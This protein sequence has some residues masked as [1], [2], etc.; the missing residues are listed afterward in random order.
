MVG[1]G[2][3]VG[4]LIFNVPASDAQ[5]DF[6]DMSSQGT[7]SLVSHSSRKH[8][9][10]RY[11][12]LQ[13]KSYDNILSL[14]GG[15]DGQRFL[16]GKTIV[17]LPDPALS[18]TPTA[19][20]PFKQYA[21]GDLVRYAA[22]LYRVT[23][24]FK[25]GRLFDS[26]NLELFDSNGD[27]FNPSPYDSDDF[28]FDSTNFDRGD[29][30]P[31]VARSGRFV[32]NITNDGLIKLTPDLTVGTNNKIT[33]LE[34]IQ[35][36]NREVYHN[37]QLGLM[38]I[39]NITA[40][41]DV[42]Y[43]QDSLDSS[44]GGIIELI[45]QDVDSTIHVETSIVGKKKYTSPNGVVL[46]N[47]MK[48]RFL[49]NVY[50]TEYADK[51]FYVEGVGTSIE[52][53]PVSDLISP[54]TWLD[55]LQTTFDT[56]A[57]DS[58]EFDAQTNSPITKDYHVIN[59]SSRDKSAWSRINR[60]F[61]EDVIKAS[62]KY[63]SYAPVLDHSYR[64]KR[65]II[66][67]VPN[68]QLENFGKVAKAPVD[69]ID[70]NQT[71][72]FSNVEGTAVEYIGGVI[73]AYS[74]EQIPLSDGMRVI[75][76]ADKD[77]QVRNNIYVV[78]WI[79]PLS[80]VDIRSAVF[81]ADGVTSVFDLNF[82]VNSTLNLEVQ[83]NG[84]NANT[85]GYTWVINSNQL[86][87]FVNTVPPAGTNITA[88]LVIN[89]QIHL[90]LADD[91]IS[92][93]DTVTITRGAVSQGKQYYFDGTSWV[94][95]QN[96]I[97]VNQAPLFTLVDQDK[98]PL[99]DSTKYVS[100]NFVGN[101]IFG[102]R[103]SDTGTTDS[104]LGIKLKYRNFN[105]IG[106]ILFSD[107]IT[108]SEFNYRV[109]VE[110]VAKTTSG[111][112]LIRNNADGS[113]EYLNQWQK[114]EFATQ[115]YQL[116]TFF[117]TQYQ[118]NSFMLNV[119]PSDRQNP[120]D[121]QSILVYVNNVALNSYRYDI[122]VVS[123]QGYLLLDTDLNVGDKLDVKVAS[124]NTTNSTL[125]EIPSNLEFNPLNVEIGEFTL[126][127]MRDHVTKVFEN[128]PDL[129]GPF[130]GS[131]NSRDL[132][133][134]KQY[135]GKIVQNLGSPH[136]AN[137][138]LNDV[139]ANFIDSVIY[140]QREYTRFKNKF[141][142]L[143]Y[144]MPL[145]NPLDPVLSVD[146]VIAEIS[147]NKSQMFSFYA[148]DMIAHGQDFKKLQY[149]V[150]DPSVVD[151]DLTTIFDGT[152]PS[153]KAVSVYKNGTLLVR[154]I[155]YVI[156]V[157]QPIVQLILSKSTN[158]SKITLAIGDQI[159]I[160][161]YVST[162]ASH[163]P[164]TPSKMGLA[165]S[166]VPEIIIDGND[167]N[168]RSVICGHDGSYTAL[169]N[170]HRDAALLEFEKRI[171]N[172][173]KVSYDGKFHDLRDYVPGGFRSTPFKKSEYDLILST[174][175]NSW[176]GKTGLRQSDYHT[177]ESS[178]PWSWNYATTTSRVDGKLMPCAY[179]RGIFQHYFDTDAPN[180]RPWEMLG[181]ADK[182][183]WWEYTY[184]PAPYTRG[185]TVLWTDLE[186]GYIADG[187]R[188]GIDSRF[189]RPN[190]IDYIPVDESGVMLSPLECLVKDYDSTNITGNFTFGDGGPVET[191][192]SQSSEYCFAQQIALALMQPAEYF[193]GNID[194]NR[195]IMRNGQ[196]VYSDTGLRDISTQS[197]H[198]ELDSA[199]NIIHVNSYITWMAEHATSLGLDI[200]SAVGDKLR[201]S[202]VQLSYKVSGFT[203]KK[204]LKVFADQ[205]TPNSTNSSVT[206]PDEDFSVVLSKSAP[207]KSVS[208]SGVIVTKTPDGFSVNGY[209]DVKPYF[210]IETSSTSGRK[211]TLKVGNLSATK[212]IRGDNRF[213]QVPYGTEFLN[214]D[215]VVDFLVSYGRY[216]TRVGFQFTD[217][218]DEDA[219]FYKDWDL[220]AR[221]FMFYAQ[222][223]WDTD[224]A[225]SLSPVGSSIK[226]SAP[227]GA[228]DGLTDKASGTRVLTED[229]RILR[230]DEYSVNRRGRDFSLSVDSSSGVYLLDIDVVNYEHILV[231]ENITRFNDLVYDPSIG[232]RQFRLKLKGNRTGD[233]DGSFG[234]AGFI[235]NEDNI[236][237]WQQ[238]KNYLKGE[239]V[240]FKNAYYT[241]I[242]NVPGA[243]SFDLQVW[244][245]SDYSKI[246][247]GLLPN[248][249]TK[250]G[251]FKKFYDIDSVNLEVDADRLGT[252]LI[253]LRPRPYFEQLQIDDTSQAKFYQGMIT[254]KGSRNSL[255]K[256][257]RAKLDNFDG[258]V[259]FYEDWALR[260]GQYGAT[261]IRQQLQLNIPENKATRDP[262]TIEI[263]NQNDSATTGMISFKPNDIWYKPRVFDKNFLGTR[264]KGTLSGDLINA[265]YVRLDDVNWTCASVA[266]LN[267]S[268]DANLVSQGDSIAVAVAENSEWNVYRVNET[269]VHTKNFSVI[270]NGTATFEF[271]TS[272]DLA[273]DDLVLIKTVNNKPAISGFY[274]V[275]SVPSNT[276]VTVNTS[277]GP[278]VQTKITGALFRLDYQRFENVSKVSGSEPL[279]GWKEND[280]LFIDNATSDGWGVYEKKNAFQ[281]SAAY[282][283]ADPFSISG[284]PSLVSGAAFGTS[285][286]VNMSND[287]MIVGQPGA[288]SIVTYT[289][290]N[291]TL[292]Q[293]SILTSPS[294]GISGFGSSVK[295][296]NNGFAVVT[297]PS[298]GGNTGVVFILQVIP[299]TNRFSIVQALTAPSLI[300]GGKFGYSAAISDDGE[301]IAIGQPEVDHGVV[302]LYH[303]ETQIIPP[304]STQQFVASG[305]TSVF[306]LSGV[307]ANPQSIDALYV[308]RNGDKLIPYVDYTLSGND[309]TMSDIPV[310]GVEIE[311]SV[312][313]AAP[314]MNYTGDGITTTFVLTGDSANPSSIYNLK[315]AINGILMVPYRDYTLSGNNVTFTTAPVSNAGIS[316]QQRTH[317]VRLG[318]Q[319]SAIGSNG[320]RYGASLDFAANG[321]ELI[322]GA[323]S[324][325]SGAGKAYVYN[326]SSVEIISDGTPGA[327]EYPVS[328]QTSRVKVTV[329]G[330]EKIQDFGYGTGEYIVD[331][332][333]SVI[334]IDNPP[335]GSRIVIENNYFF[336]NDTISF[337]APEPNANA[338][339]SVKFSPSESRVF[340]GAPYAD[341]SKTDVGKVLCAVDQGRLYGVNTGTVVN[342]VL[343][344][345][346]YLIINERW[347]PVA[348]G[349]T[350][351]AVISAIQ[352][353]DVPG[354]SVS[355]VGG[356]LH[357]SSNDAVTTNKLKISASN[358]TVLADLGLKTY[359]NQ[360][361]L[362]GPSS[363]EYGMF[364]KEL[365]MSS[366]SL[367]LVV[368]SDRASSS[369]A[370]TFDSN[371]TK[372]DGSA[373]SFSYSTKQSGAVFTYQ[374][375]PYPS[376][377]V[378]ASGSFIP[379][380][381]L[382]SG[383]VDSMDG[384]GSGISI[385]G[386]ILFVGAPGDDTYVSNGGIIF[387]FA[388][389][390]YDRVW[391]LIRSETP[392]VNHTLINRVSLIDTVKNVIVADLDFID[393]YKGKI[394]GVAEQEVTYSTS[395]DPAEYNVNSANQTI[396][397]S[398]MLWGPDQVGQ[399]WWDISAVRW[400][401]YEQGDIDFRVANWGTA[402]P[403]SVVRCYEWIESTV[404]PAQF[405]DSTAFALT[406]SHS[407]IETID[408]FGNS[409]VTYYYWVGGKT[410]VP[411]VSFRSIS[412]NDIEELISN[413]KTAGIPYAA[414]IA[415]NAIALYNCKSYLRD[416]EIVLSIDYDIEENDSNIHA[417][418][419]LISQG[420]VNSSP[421]S[422]IITKLIDSLA[423]SDSDGR[424]VPDVKLTAGRRYGKEFRPRQ[425]MFR[426]RTSAL[427]VAIDYINSILSATPILLE[428]NVSNIL[429]SEN[430]PSANSGQWNE[431]VA[432][433]T[434]L[435]YINKVILP[436][437]YKILVMSNDLVASRWTIHELAYLE[438]GITK[439]WKLNRVQAYDNS[440]Y[441][442]KTNWVAAGESNNVIPSL[443]VNYSYQ[444][445]EITPSNGLVVKIKDD[446][447][448]YYTIMK[449]TGT[450]WTPIVIEQATIK[451]YDGIWDQS[452]T[453]QGFDNESFDLQMFDSWPTVEI[454]NILRAVYDD[455]FVDDLSIEMNN[456]FF[457]MMQHLMQ[458]QKYVDW[459]FKT[460]FIKVEQ[461]QH[462][463]TQIPVYQKDNQDL[464]SQY[465]NETKPFHTKIREF[466]LKYNGEDEVQSNVSDFDVP[467]Y[468]VNST[469]GYRS[470]NGSET[471][472]QFILDLEPYTAW[473][474]NHT[475][476]VESI[477][478][479][480][481]GDGYISPPTLSIVGG[482]GSGATAVAEVLGGQITAVRITNSGSG[483]TT[484]PEVVLSNV[485]GSGALLAVRLSN[486][487][488]RRI[489]ETIKFDRTS[490]DNTGFLVQFKDGEGGLIDIRNEKISK[491]GEEPKGVIDILLSI[492]EPTT[493]ITS[494][495]GSAL[496]DYR[497]FNDASGRIQVAYL[498]RAGG[499]N[500]Y[501][502]QDI[503]RTYS[504]AGI[505]AL[506]LS[507][508]TVVVDSSFTSY[509]SPVDDWKATTLYNPGDVV[510]YA[511]NA[512]KAMTR[513]TSGTQF[514]FG[515]VATLIGTTTEEYNLNIGSAQAWDTLTSYSVNEYF[516][517]LTNTGKLYRVTSP[518]TSGLL[519]SV[520]SFAL[521]TGE[522]FT[523]HLDRTWAYYSPTTGQFGKDLG[524]LFKGVDYP[525]VKVIG[526]SFSMQPGFDV[527]SYDIGQF[528]AFV[529]DESGAKVLDPAILDQ[530]IYS[531]FT[532]TALGTRP[533]DIIIR[534]NGFA[535]VYSSHAPEE[536]VPGR[537]FDTLDMKVYT[538]PS[539]DWTNSGFGFDVALTTI[540]YTDG[541]STY[542]F[543]NPT[544]AV[545]TVIVFTAQAGRLRENDGFTIDR[546]TNTITVLANLL[547]GDKIF[548]YA[549]DQGGRG[550]LFTK[551]FI[552]D[553]STAGYEI[554][555]DE[556][557]IGELIVSID[558]QYVTNWTV[559]P[560][561]TGISIILFDTAP[562][563]NAALIVHV[564][565]EPGKFNNIVTTDFVM[566]GTSYPADYTIN[567]PNVIGNDYPY[568]EKIIVELNGYRLRPP[569]QQYY[570]SDGS[571]LAYALPSSITV[572]PDLISDTDVL[573]SV[574]GEIKTLYV[575][576]TLSPSDGSS[577]RTVEFF[578][579]QPSGAE[580]V[581]SLLLDA[582]Y[583][584]LDSDTIRISAGVTIQTDDVVTVTSFTN[585]DALKIRTQVFEGSSTI[586]TTVNIGF[587]YG[588]F[589]DIEFDG[590]SVAVSL[591]S[592]Y[593]LSR[594]VT[595]TG[596]LWVTLSTD[597]VGGGRFLFP[598][599]DYRMLSPTRLEIA[600]GV[601]VT[602]STIISVTSFYETAQKTSTGFR[603]FHDMNENV[604]YYRIADAYTTNLVQ[605]IGITDD[606]I[607][608]EDASKLG[609][610]SS[611]NNYPGVV[612]VNGER[613]TY[614]GRD[615]TTNTLSQL[616]RGTSGTPIMEHL[617]G[618]T[619]VSADHGQEIPN[620]H[621][622]TWY[623]L[624]DG[625]PSNGLGLQY[626]TTQQA[627]FIEQ[628]V[629]TVPNAGY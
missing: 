534:G 175:F 63:N 385:S 466:V 80:N 495:S 95:G 144:S 353:Q 539:D 191:A 106:D 107:Y 274:T 516:T 328:A 244:V 294:T 461:T 472:D 371:K 519:F 448:G 435:G 70:L 171:F 514:A 136:L 382:T 232:A 26:A 593:D 420:D 469:S 200:T 455:I 383:D 210:T 125:Y 437:G 252:G 309:V 396:S 193:G 360:Q 303:L 89:D 592:Q 38:L 255:D 590:S 629:A 351:S 604:N 572:N 517:D 290:K 537:V 159:E 460:S 610:P 219:G 137:L 308:T 275:V 470:P 453:L 96:K 291:G 37:N 557:S 164:Q 627:K 206:I 346:G 267:T 53:I 129:V 350:L 299:E 467:A 477:D 231:F 569:N 111:S 188:K 9:L 441:I 156:P 616:R 390:E 187:D 124:A 505:N 323:P 14:H 473:R 138:F 64:A 304:V 434:E 292:S 342:P 29:D 132:G 94:L 444:L 23:T 122:Q 337:A 508:T 515:S 208:Y 243:S 542:S 317:Y 217:K 15:I 601:L 602:P 314:E 201:K 24:P 204:Y 151:F 442:I 530:T 281:T 258:Q 566:T 609:E 248:L 424:I 563:A 149:T 30:I 172:N 302:H 282:Y 162:N 625:E 42:L 212:Y 82:D 32:I 338:G 245:K 341:S 332:F 468:Y 357:L 169:F 343:T 229:F 462:A 185:N 417:E 71:D 336:E 268:L 576:W 458:E 475:L 276:K 358:Y 447:R 439:E 257:L 271:D 404:P 143:L 483:Y 286:S 79:K 184:G 352:G 66:E 215:Q 262:V 405:S 565:S 183:D 368:A 131:N 145:T 140:A 284:D 573:V 75:F 608:V 153:A 224:V 414:F 11:V 127:Q 549:I 254:Q 507:G 388:L 362:I 588:G 378:T 97:S 506:D 51:E 584:V 17:F 376:D 91:N 356:K 198:G 438:D 558:G 403:D 586:S 622:K 135:G 146:E 482:G 445:A 577:I 306:T 322:I 432:D 128:T 44:I 591:V 202:T 168:P 109:G 479:V 13:Y 347:V 226:F 501:D 90:E 497:I 613:I 60:W 532:D 67:F 329:D 398:G 582:E 422:D 546:T 236:S 238:N 223:G 117:A 163:I 511:G 133:N 118:K 380:Q 459:L 580:I 389:N 27:W 39:P 575:H 384:F 293:D 40:N 386:N 320:D 503:L 489:S 312:T 548:V 408:E 12:D 93:G 392:K 77:D 457:I 62:A 449:Y 474:D 496:P 197:V 366:D 68:I 411:D 313:R 359:I 339:Y 513:F 218:L 43:Y 400:M 620:A 626:S 249:S 20:A 34:G 142:E 612:F 148:S 46:T 484:T 478:I 246:N 7:T 295:V 623:T 451:I 221:E 190:L 209:D 617:A 134:I 487:K 307:N 570:L 324:A 154:G 6:I 327:Y 574:D 234:A 207:I 251:A 104:E 471:I 10:L 235:L 170:D 355:S 334:F 195:Q 554:P 567:L 553:A 561:E 65:P 278:V 401:E 361:E 541:I 544:G 614:Y 76:A 141:L 375:I 48:I 189:A 587:D 173:L 423:G 177:A 240:K 377:N 579:P 454:Q 161:E 618:A 367:T 321:Q 407:R 615:L 525:G 316:I 176:L 287:Y 213:L 598:N 349:M 296:S 330:V 16:E 624:G 283:P 73:N 211:E 253:G 228:V 33:V 607:Y 485:T 310:N 85:A 428:K 3:D 493:G 99:S 488:V 419:Q 568:G 2:T 540:R 611:A 510:V 116:Q 54:E 305:L 533:E 571:T 150:I 167:T 418:Y 285:V 550:L 247:K 259:N 370:T 69:I 628:Y 536:M 597:G 512:Y 261:D 415:P 55:S 594:P 465:V 298:S 344:A 481:A 250:A 547:D 335:A 41:L 600:E 179:W 103:V 374:Y 387:S 205:A 108:S 47:G 21:E 83:V 182:P 373:T 606:T 126:G 297:A 498:R 605:P 499:I 242:E 463:I 59:R 61:H 113:V 152:V 399:V 421:S 425:T 174:H 578:D 194:K 531:Q 325:N 227:Q 256:L 4:E 300:S 86:L 288:E 110:S 192:W 345:N 181:F 157:D 446:G 216:L 456:W 269:E 147:Y 98:I 230:S 395:Y 556:S 45:D 166:Y 264:Q 464:V 121:P 393:P 123:G 92:A 476:E 521:V 5:N 81:T 160:R 203:D 397:P 621:A 552:T 486:S 270:S 74:V 165:P 266:T 535:D 619:V 413:P 78:R 102:Y 500:E 526:P 369:S 492:L 543:T 105:N 239:I 406:A 391:N 440:D 265:G 115:Q 72:A 603:I 178:D 538:T 101:K 409:K 36:G 331:E 315:I 412:T 311:I 18:A 100:N 410:T 28:G 429:A 120:L 114:N 431:I 596:Y 436:I 372:F 318:S 263:L 119:I 494:T 225:I 180:L 155:E 416:S 518:F 58:S 502:L 52:L 56:V 562:D 443:I 490:V 402:F 381:Q 57:F 450:S 1:N 363:E 559:E 589:D 581:V 560:L 564:F 139:Q 433:L 599:V 289:S 523:N 529:V 84:V 237:D 319:T 430:I 260:T 583:S 528:D 524:Q 480:L 8:R 50:P 273:V 527:S 35:Y 379:G 504:S 426:D 551:Q 186:N 585:H 241:A 19:W 130:I 340:I 522:E 196:W 25:S 158:Q 427:K 555:V 233:W 272:H 279:Q 49:D 364:G 222:Q 220:A 491:L 354:L 326:R 509:T 277:Y 280:K 87:T 214:V 520:D 348:S 301:W 365:D 31:E 333:G 545:D 22:T 112:Q 88:T 199:G 394:S 595:N 452:L